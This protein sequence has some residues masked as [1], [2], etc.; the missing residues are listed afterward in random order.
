MTDVQ[1]WVAP[2]YTGLADLLE[3]SS[4]T[5][6]DLP[7][8]CEGWLVRHVVAHVT[9]PAR[10]TPESFGADMAAA[11]GDFTAFSNNVAARDGELPVAD[12]LAQLRSEQLHSWEPPR[13]GAAGALNH[14]VIHSLDITVAL[15]LPSVAPAEALADVLARLTAAEGSVFGLDLSDV[16]LEATD[17]PWSWG[18]GRVTQA[19]SGSLVSLL[20]GRT[21]PDGTSLRH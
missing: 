4:D 12:L 10:M 11:G 3:S 1:I 19:D 20:G 14:A 18:A 21:L 17:A 9:M 8:L 6:W 13:G 7:S 15:D 16:R 5:V 2:T